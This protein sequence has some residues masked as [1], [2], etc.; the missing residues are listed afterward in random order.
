MTY[1]IR[2]ARMEEVSAVVDLLNGCSVQEIGEPEYSLSEWT[3]DWESEHYDLAR[4]TRIALNEMGEIVAYADVYDVPP[5][6]RGN[7]ILRVHPDYWGQGIEQQLMAWVDERSQ[8]NLTRA[9][10]GV[11]VAVRLHM[12]DSVSKLR[13]LVEAHGYQ[14]I[15]NYLQMRIDLTSEPPQPIWSEG[16]TLRTAIPKTDD[17]AIYEAYLDSFADHWGFVVRP[18]EVIMPMFT[19]PADNYDPS[20]WF[21]AMDGETVAGICLC[22]PHVPEDDQRGWVD[23]LGVTR[24]YRNRGIGLALLHH[25]FGEYTRRGYTHVGLGVDAESLTGA[26]RLYEKAGMYRTRA[27]CAYEKVVREGMDLAVQALAGG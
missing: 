20:L 24:A 27:L 23:L 9:A 4:D 22:L 13:A 17:R 14:H 1:T 11:K 21:L 10:E 19:S 5:Y 2:P 25:A 3:A 8:L 26:T 12:Y 6:E 15:R 18:F 7:A 16:I